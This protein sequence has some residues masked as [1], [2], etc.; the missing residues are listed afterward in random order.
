MKKKIHVKKSAPAAELAHHEPKRVVVEKADNGYITSTHTETGHK[1]IISK[2][3]K[4][5][6]R[7]IHRLLK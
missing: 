6:T 2:T 4:E 3:K 5:A 1:Q 7:H